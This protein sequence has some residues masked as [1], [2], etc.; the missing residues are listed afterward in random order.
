MAEDE[1]EE[2][3]RCLLVGVRLVQT[4]S[5]LGVSAES[6]RAATNEG[7]A[8]LAR[9]FVDESYA[10]VDEALTESETCGNERNGYLAGEFVAVTDAVGTKDPV[11]IEAAVKEFDRQLSDTADEPAES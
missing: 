9:F 5:Q 1:S 4:L 7:E 8:E 2:R 10:E 6:L 11:R 3:F